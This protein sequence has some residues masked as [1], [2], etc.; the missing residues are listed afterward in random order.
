MVGT[1]QMR[2]IRGCVAAASYGLVFLGSAL[3]QSVTIGET[4][5]ESAGDS[6]NGNL[7]LAQSAKLGQAAT[8]QSL[9]F[10]V[11]A[12]SGNLI[13]GIYDA[14]GPGGGPGALKASTASFVPAK[15]WN[16]AKVVTPV[17]LAS[18]AYWL[19]YLPSSSALSF[20]KTNAS[21]ACAYY[22]YNFG[23]MPSKFSTSPANC[24]ATTWSLYATLTATA[25][26]SPS[27]LN[28]A[29]GSS[30]GATVSTKPT[31]NLCAAG[32]ASSV[33]GTGPWTW[34]CAGSNGG[35]TA[36]C[37]ATKT[38][39]TPVNGVCGSAN[40]ASL[41][42]A[43][44]TNLCTTGT[45]ST[46]S[47]A[48]PWSW[49]CAGSNGGS[50]ATCSATKT[51]S[52]GGSGSGGST[53]STPALIQHV[54]STSNPFPGNGISGNNFKIPLPNPVLAGDALVLAIS[55]PTG[56]KPSI[57][58][59]L[60]NAWPSSAACTATTVGN[61]TAAIYV[62]P[63]SHAGTLA[64]PG[65]VTVGLGA[66]VQP[67]QYTLS[68]FNKIATSSPVNGCIQKAGI[69]PASG[70]IS[71]GSLTPTA[72]NNANGG[73]VIW[74]YT[75]SAANTSGYPTG[76]TAASGFTLLDGNNIGMSGYISTASQWQIQP[77]QGAVTPS[78]VEAG[79]NGDTYNSLAIALKIAA[80]GGSMPAGIHIN[81]V[82]HF[83]QQSAGSSLTLETPVTGNLR[84]LAFS[85]AGTVSSITDN[86][87]GSSWTI[88]QGSNNPQASIA[89]A[90]NRGPLPTLKITVRFSSVNYPT[91]IRFFDIQGAAAAPF[92]VA[93]S[94]NPTTCP[95]PVG[96]TSAA[97]PITPTTAKGLTIAGM[98]M[99]TG[100]V[101]GVVGPANAI[102]DLVYYSGETDFDMMENADAVGHYYNPD[103]STENWSWT[104]A[105]HSG[106]NCQGTQA[107]HFKSQ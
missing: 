96:N 41:S 104:T 107:V 101:E 15:G 27:A 47:G 30:N 21:G 93:A 44:T 103:L 76:W 20:V 70:T 95:A 106:A 9:S 42:S 73:N 22:G 38:A 33:S 1:F 65:A 71:P 52:G 83:T 72:N 80:A 99:G 29:C 53:G 13:L 64:T 68:E 74:S 61:M 46:V 34:S 105:P 85:L 92:D 10:Y 54:S 67:F 7:L 16:T 78:I 3:A 100:P 102:F 51:A 17:S 50:T 45:A 97:P 25:S 82:L 75:A 84:V 91:S 39:S 24:T 40:G 77:T 60:G 12:A 37:S 98:P 87:T 94:N 32:T 79:D 62:L 69:S 55:Y 5:V 43:P 23:A 6:Q 48:G 89:F 11:T 57:T 66:S 81:K 58:D 19:A 35:T 4:A 90:P 63:N 18:G 2:F 8:I 26:T 86:D 14:T 49:S 31:A 28:G 36:T 56:N 59:N 88:E